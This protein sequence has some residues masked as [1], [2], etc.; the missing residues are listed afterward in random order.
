MGWFSRLQ[1]QSKGVRARFAFFSALTITGIITLIWLLSFPLRL[2]EDT[3]EPS[4]S[5][6]QTFINAT[7]AEFRTQIEQYDPPEE[8]TEASSTQKE[9]KQ[10]VRV[11]TTTRP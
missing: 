9:R 8:D 2:Q 7:E 3:E 10:E 5:D 11:G 6:I 4:D 1:Q